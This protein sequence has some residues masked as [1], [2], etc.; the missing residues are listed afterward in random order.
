MGVTRAERRGFEAAAFA[1]SGRIGGN[2]RHR[3][4]GTRSSRF[5]A[6]LGPAIALTPTSH[7]MS[8]AEDHQA[9]IRWL[10][11][12]YHHGRNPF[13][14][15]SQHLSLHYRG[16]CKSFTSMPYTGAYRGYRHGC[17]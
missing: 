7:L 10:R 2:R 8:A 9:F 12:P 6:T 11:R 14:V 15:E 3:R 17:E 13:A 5:A 4:A 16:F 1:G